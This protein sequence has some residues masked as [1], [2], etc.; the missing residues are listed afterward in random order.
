LVKERLNVL[1]FLM[2]SQGTD[3]MSCY[4]YPKKTTP[5]IDDL[6]KKGVTFE[7]TFTPCVWTRDSHAALFTGRFLSSFIPPMLPESIPT[8]SE[9]LNSIGYKTVA[10]S[11]NSWVNNAPG[12]V[13]RGF[14]DV[15]M[16]H[17]LL[18]NEKKENINRLFEEVG[19]PGERDKGSLYTVHLAEKW[20]D[21]NCDDKT[22]FFMFINVLETHW[23][24][25]P[26]QPFR[27]K[28]LLHGVTDEMAREIPQFRW[29]I[30]LECI[31]RNPWEWSVML[32]LLDGETATLDHRLGLLLNYFEE[33]GILDNTVIIVTSDHHDVFWEHPGYEGHC[34]TYDVNIHIPLII[35][36]P[37]E[38]FPKGKRVT[39][40][41]QLHDIFPTLMDLIGIKDKSIM[42]SIQ[43]QSLFTAIND[44]P[45]R[46]FAVCERSIGPIPGAPLTIPKCKAYRDPEYK[47]IWTFSP[48]FEGP[49]RALPDEL[50][51]IVKDPLEQHNLL[52]S[53]PGER[54]DP[55]MFKKALELRGKLEKFLSSLEVPPVHISSELARKL[56]A[57]GFI[58]DIIVK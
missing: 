3:N 51:N 2:D 30:R 9:A 16:V 52:P 24:Y 36:G 25:W 32:S 38:Y 57:W 31:P 29:P 44:E 18:K 34:S 56:R 12:G 54:G 55:K 39:H 5:V 46:N 42:K 41:T 1:I 22:N 11:N 45:R 13:L 4:G 43:S 27:E 10:F 53:H 33:K 35:K 37:S 28:Y 40:I 49:G 48:P 8:I 50:Y 26:P 21:E 23:S 7:N 17:Q 58:R 19:E 15:F 6:A 20:L 14:K 47:Y